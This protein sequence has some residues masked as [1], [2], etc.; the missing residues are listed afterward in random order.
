MGLSTNRVKDYVIEPGADLRSA[1]LHP[2]GRTLGR[3]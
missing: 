2:K 1:D 3:L